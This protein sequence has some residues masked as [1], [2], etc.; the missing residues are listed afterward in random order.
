MVFTAGIA[1]ALGTATAALVQA[2]NFEKSLL[3]I[4]GVAMADYMNTELIKLV[5]QKTV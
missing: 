1:V 4:H 5:K 3:E 2:A